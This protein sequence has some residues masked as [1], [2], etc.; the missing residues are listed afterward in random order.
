MR[1]GV[2]ARQPRRSR[3]FNQ[4]PGASCAHPL[5]VQKTDPEFRGDTRYFN[6]T[7]KV[8]PYG[9]GA[10]LAYSWAP[11]KNVVICPYPNGVT[12]KVS[13]ASH[14]LP[15]GTELP[16]GEITKNIHEPTTARGGSFEYILTSSPVKS[17]YLVVRGRFIHPPWAHG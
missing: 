15:N 16:G 8:E 3:C 4:L 10:E 17:W 11:K 9:L 6:V 13:Q 2:P 1:K 14:I 5:E 7:L 12:L